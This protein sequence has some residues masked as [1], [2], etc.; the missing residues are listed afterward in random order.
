MFGG[1]GE[2]GGGAELSGCLGVSFRHVSVIADILL[3]CSH[4]PIVSSAYFLSLS[5]ILKN[6][7]SYKGMCHIVYLHFIKSVEV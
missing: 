7:N 5:C 3:N 4:I 6:V 1:W 2:G